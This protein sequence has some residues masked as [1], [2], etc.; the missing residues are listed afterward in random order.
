MEPRQPGK[1]EA[2]LA[3]ASALVM[4]W[5]MA[6]PQERYWMKLRA[7]Q[8]LHRLASALARHEGHAGMRD[9]LAGRDFQRYGM[10]YQLSRARDALGRAL[11]RMK[12]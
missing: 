11:E 10:A 9:E 6:P 5:Y 12:P 2:V 7:L 1:A 4:T 8:S 3:L